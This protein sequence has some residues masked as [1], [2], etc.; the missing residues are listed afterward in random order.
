MTLAGCR[1][2]TVTWKRNLREF[3]CLEKRPDLGREMFVLRHNIH[4]ISEDRR[5]KTESISKAERP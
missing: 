3:C 2:N 1:V 5:P 4:K